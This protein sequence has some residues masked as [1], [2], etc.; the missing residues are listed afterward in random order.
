MILDLTAW[1]L[2]KPLVLVPI[3]FSSIAEPLPAAD[4]NV[5]FAFVV[6]A[7]AKLIVVP[8]PIFWIESTLRADCTIAP[9][10][11]VAVPP[12]SASI[13][14][15]HIWT[16][17]ESAPLAVTLR[18]P[19]ELLKLIEALS[20]PEA[21]V[22]PNIIFFVSAIFTLP[23]KVAWGP[24]LAMLKASLPSIWNFIPPVD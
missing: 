5:L 7:P 13:V 12:S 3:K 18:I 23:A 17:W 16:L 8:E 21:A 22:P 1:L 9:L 24:L 15:P 11:K 14:S 2:P 20:S 4:L 19:V 6:I 10:A